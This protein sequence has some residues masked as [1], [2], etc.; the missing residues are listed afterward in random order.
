MSS[1]LLPPSALGLLSTDV[2]W[3][4]QC[5]F[6]T[7]A[8]PTI[9][10][11][12]SKGREMAREG[13]AN[14]KLGEPSWCIYY[15][16]S[17]GAGGQLLRRNYTNIRVQTL[18]SARTEWD[19]TPHEKHL[20]SS[21]PYSDEHSIPG[22]TAPLVVHLLVESMPIYQ[23][24]PRS[25]ISGDSFVS[26]TRRQHQHRLDPTN[27]PTPPSASL[28]TPAPRAK[29]A[30][31]PPLGSVPRRPRRPRRSFCDFALFSQN[32][33][34]MESDPNATPM[35]VPPPH[36]KI[37]TPPYFPYG[38][39]SSA[40]EYV[41]QRPLSSLNKPVDRLVQSRRPPPPRTRYA[42]PPQRQSLHGCPEVSLS[43]ETVVLRRDGPITLNLSAQG[44]ELS[45]QTLGSADTM[46]ALVIRCKGGSIRSFFYI[47]R[48]NFNDVRRM[49]YLRII[50][51]SK[52]HGD[53][54]SLPLDQRYDVGGGV[55]D[56][57]VDV[58]EHCFRRGRSTV[59]SV[60]SKEPEVD[61]KPSGRNDTK[62]C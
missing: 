27:P 10:T 46:W 47:L 9:E 6:C 35:P 42:P 29:A 56:V 32:A 17:I 13:T 8:T 38:T 33:M 54:H 39:P 11:A 51:V 19:R 40:G 34:V 18:A 4:S 37:T 7:E 3:V 43:Y 22:L 12:L 53:C 59:E 50:F 16:S 5:L 20:R 30:S 48:P 57:L 61:V 14:R 26:P 15:H 58:V 60:E 45:S 55:R 2:H 1:C 62:L 41:Q 23:T 44:A 25:V 31:P 21:T 49:V 24:F 36:A 52:S 28:I